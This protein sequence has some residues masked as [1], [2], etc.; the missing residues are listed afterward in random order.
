MNRPLV[1]PCH[2]NDTCT[3]LS[4]EDVRRVF[5][6]FEIGENGGH[7]LGLYLTERILKVCGLSF[8]FAP[9]E[10]GMRFVVHLG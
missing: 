10:F 8:E 2:P 4:P 5:V 3:P 9:L 7:G 6:P 1:I